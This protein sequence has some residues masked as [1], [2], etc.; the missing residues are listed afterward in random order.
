MEGLRLAQLALLQV[1]AKVNTISSKVK[2]VTLDIGSWL[3]IPAV[4]YTTLVMTDVN[5]NYLH[6]LGFGIGCGTHNTS[7]MSVF[8]IWVGLQL[9][10]H[11]GITD[12]IESNAKRN[13][14]IFES[15][16]E[17]KSLKVISRMKS[18]MNK[19][20]KQETPNKIVIESSGVK[21]LME[22][23][24]S[25]LL[26]GHQI[27]SVIL[28]RYSPSS[29]RN[30]P[31]VDLIKPPTC[32][33]HL[34]ESSMIKKPRFVDSEDS[35]NRMYLNSLNQ[36]L[37]D[38]LSATF[39]QI[40]LKT[41][42]LP[43]EGLCLRICS[44]ENIIGQ[45]VKN[46]DVNNFV[47]SMR[48]H[49][50]IMD[51]TVGRRSIFQEVVASKP[52][53]VFIDLPA[54]AGLGSVLFIPECCRQSILNEFSDLSGD[55]NNIAL[56]D[57]LA[58]SEYLNDINSINRTLI[59]EL[60]NDDEAFSLGR[61]DIHLTEKS[62]E[63]PFGAASLFCIRFGLITQT[64]IV[65]QLIDH[66]LVKAHKVEESS[67]YLEKLSQLVKDG[68]V[69]VTEDLAREQEEKMK[70]EGIFRQV[71][72]IDSLIN[73]WSPPPKTQIIGRS[74]NLS[75]GEINITEDIYKYKM[76]LQTGPN[77]VFSMDI[78]TKIDSAIPPPI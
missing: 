11:D 60:R 27:P 13:S 5:E 54:W 50:T 57:F 59:V 63:N 3:G 23:V 71:P 56:L 1:P 7:V 17:M 49:I 8:P 76:Q 40:N 51:S 55:N 35:E 78:G 53:L 65:D 22:T 66:V 38:N 73:W 16:K 62:D 12:K 68:I 25:F 19:S 72:Y 44:Q 30:S 58:S 46:D 24:L 75:S 14:E 9:M 42:N 61:L 41:I 47:A 2:S 70:H 67:K 69:K 20:V 4:P 32:T 34:E 18:A 77:S 26:E 28:F 64:T 48:Q 33:N 39:P 36:W 10:G 37:A 29:W 52:E 21:N 6:Q 74:L 43:P 15:L 45:D 31:D